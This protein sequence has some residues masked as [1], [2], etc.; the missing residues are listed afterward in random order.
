MS[1]HLERRGLQPLLLALILAL[2]A[3]GLAACGDDGDD[4]TSG[5]DGTETSDTDADAPAELEKITITTPS[6]SLGFLAINVAVDQG[7][8]EDE[9]LEV[10]MINL[11]GPT[12]A[13]VSAVLAGEAWAFIGGLEHVMLANARGSDLRGITAVT[14]RSS[15]FIVSPT[16]VD[17]STKALQTEALRGKRV[18][19]G[20]AGGS[21]HI[22]FLR[23]LESLGLDP[24]KDVTLIEGDDT[25][26][27]A[28]VASGQADFALVTEPSVSKGIIDGLWGEPIFDLASFKPYVQL[29]VNLPQKTIDEDP[30]TVQGFVDALLRGAQF[31]Y[32]EPEAA[33]AI[34]NEALAESADPEALELAFERLMA[35]EAW[36][37]DGRFADGGIEAV[38]ELAVTQADGL[39]LD[40]EK[41]FDEQFLPEP[42]G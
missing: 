40:A 24:A 11:Q 28:A 12:P 10:E 9:G 37:T 27:V 35:L 15:S 32:D 21:P 6:P 18:A 25:A 34:A 4:T 20:S 5:T 22:A 23:Y 2:L 17:M 26:R 41:A 31:I 39:E 30:E 29:S 3:A 33:L 7:F 19:L 14:R 42:S 1:R 38:T 13:H 8:F 16:P 36:S